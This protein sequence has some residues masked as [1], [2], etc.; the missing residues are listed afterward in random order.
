MSTVKF[1]LKRKVS[2]QGAGDAAIDSSSKNSEQLQLQMGFHSCFVV[3]FFSIFTTFPGEGPINTT[4]G[5]RSN[6]P[7]FPRVSIN[8]LLLCLGLKHGLTYSRAQERLAEEMFIIFLLTPHCGINSRRRTSLAG[9][10]PSH[11]WTGADISTFPHLSALRDLTRALNHSFL[12]HGVFFGHCK[13]LICT[14]VHGSGSAFFTWAPK[15]RRC[16]RGGKAPAEGALGKKKISFSFFSVLNVIINKP[17]HILICE[18]LHDT[19]TNRI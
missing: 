1:M 5:L 8:I 13:G 6:Y 10:C 18:L 3:T 9:P 16:D 2:T 11:A 7:F 12:P 15:T 4:T 14:G 17:D 19:K